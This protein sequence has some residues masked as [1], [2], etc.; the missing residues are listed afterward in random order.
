MRFS[1]V[2]RAIVII[3]IKIA[4]FNLTLIILEN[5]CFIEKTPIGSFWPCAFF[6]G[7]MFV[8][9]PCYV[10]CK[11]FFGKGSFCFF[12]MIKYLDINLLNLPTKTSAKA[13][14]GRCAA[15]F[16]T[17]IMLKHKC[18]QSVAL[19]KRGL[20]VLHLKNVEPT[21]YQM[22]SHWSYETQ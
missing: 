13:L 6:S 14:A 3:I 9:H 7:K 22:R 15:L 21:S 4:G 1:T 18:L 19:L 17:R 2:L 11:T 16:I 10:W 12:F 5:I 20:M 8:V